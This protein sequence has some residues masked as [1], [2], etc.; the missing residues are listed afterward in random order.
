MTLPGVIRRSRRGL[1][2][3]ARLAREERAYFAGALHPSMWRRGFCSHR[4]YSYPGISDPSLP[5]ISDLRNHLYCPTLNPPSARI[6]VQDKAAFADALEARGLG[7]RAPTTY[8]VVTDQGLRLRSPAAREAF[9][10]QPAVVVKPAAR[11]GG[12]GVRLLSPAEVEAMGA[13][14]GVELLVQEAIRQHP[15]LALI[16]PGSLNT[17]RLLA[18]RLSEDECILAAAAH[19]WGT[20]ASGPVDNVSRGGLASSVDLQTGR[21]GSAVG[22][23]RNR[24]RVEVDHHPDSGRP[25]T[26]EYVPQWAEVR[27]LT[28]RLMAA[29][30][31]LNHVGWDV[32]VSDRGPLVVEGNG[33]M[34][35]PALFQFSGPFAYDPRLRDYYVRHRLLSAG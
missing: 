6:L 31:E 14:R 32:A 29:F 21:L 17:A 8:G 2:V 22:R 11:G 12:V 15:D 5:Y 24:R 25:I 13:P 28:L 33:F 10:A 35:A 19:R 7:N 18:V 20:A 23:P 34:P 9:H 1:R 27:D 16:H 30:P 26:G 3:L 4:R